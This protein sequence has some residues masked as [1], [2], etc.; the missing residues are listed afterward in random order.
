MTLEKALNLAQC[1]DFEL[2][3]T[4]IKLTTYLSFFSELYCVPLFLRGNALFKQ[5][6]L[7][8]SNLA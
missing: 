5:L 8:R 6:Y 2:M 4:I 7:T 3:L 1:L